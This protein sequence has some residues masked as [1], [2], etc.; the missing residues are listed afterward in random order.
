MPMQTLSPKRHRVSGSN[1]PTGPS[2]FTPPLRAN[3]KAGS[4]PSRLPFPPALLDPTALLLPHL[5]LLESQEGRPCSPIPSPL[6]IVHQTT[7]DRLLH[8]QRPPHQAN[9]LLNLPPHFPSLNHL[10]TL[11]P[12]LNCLS[13][14]QIPHLHHQPKTSTIRRLR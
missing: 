6:T 1:C 4:V 10:N 14:F 11:D 12:L 3:V 5:H 2:T 9:H 13:S 8:H 7:Q